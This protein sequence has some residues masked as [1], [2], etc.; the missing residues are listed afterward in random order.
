[1]MERISSNELLSIKHIDLNLNTYIADIEWITSFVCF[2]PKHWGQTV[3]YL[4]SITVMQDT[5]I[6]GVYSMKPSV[7][8]KRFWDIQ[9]EYQ[10]NHG[11]KYTEHLSSF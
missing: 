11:K 1:M 7:E 2:R 3:M 8:N 10:L 9:I 5:E 6:L 4:R